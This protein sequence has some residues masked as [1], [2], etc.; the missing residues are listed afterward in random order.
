MEPALT[1]ERGVAREDTAHVHFDVQLGSADL[2]ASLTCDVREGLTATPKELPP[3]WFYDERGSALFDRITTLPEY[4][5]TRAE[6]SVLD[7][8]VDEIALVTGA[9]TLVELGS[10]TSAK[11]RILLSALA[12]RGALT[13]FVALD[14][15]GST[16]RRAAGAI[17]GDYGIP[18]HAVVGDF[19]SDLDAIPRQ[20]RRLVAFLG[21]TVGN[22]V[23]HER[24]RF[25]ARLTDVLSKGDALLLGADLV[26]DP[27]RLVAAYDDSSGVTAEFNRNV[28][29]VINRELDADFV[30]ERYAHVA[31]YDAE[32]EWVEMHLRSDVAQRVTIRAAG[33]TVDLAAGEQI[34]TEISAKFR[35]PGIEAELVAAG[36]LPTRWW[37][38]AAGDFGLSL[39]MRA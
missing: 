16:L 25:F 17:S 12:A 32:N 9:D 26:K 24:A 15:S 6:R 21:S 33:L 4:Y 34:R 39:S 2:A 35:R 28:L 38:D 8:V 10:G 22:L 27:A 23:P 19:E 20:G 7:A 37:T 18:V 13:R 11:T 14:V 29:H 36:L 1:Q 3:K 30:P 31:S 5:P